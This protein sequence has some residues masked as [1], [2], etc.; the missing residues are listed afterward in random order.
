MEY[1]LDYF[2]KESVYAESRQAQLT[3]CICP[4]CYE[5]VTFAGGSGTYQRAH[6]RH[7]AHL[8]PET[9]EYRVSPGYEAN[10]L[11]PAIWF[12]HQGG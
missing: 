9:C 5:E 7:L 2:T 8:G 3:Q 11:N 1:A 12:L 6:F 10:P 4:G